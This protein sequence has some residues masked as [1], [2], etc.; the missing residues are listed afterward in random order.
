MSY[1]CHNLRMDCSK[2]YTLDFMDIPWIRGIVSGPLHTADDDITGGPFG[3]S[4][5]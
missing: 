1:F 4:F 3:L 5:A 2:S